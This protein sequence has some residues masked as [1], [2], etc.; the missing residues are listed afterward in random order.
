MASSKVNVGSHVC[1]SADAVELF[2]LP[3]SKAL[4]IMEVFDLKLCG[5][6][7]Q[8]RAAPV[9]PDGLDYTGATSWLFAS[10]FRVVG[11]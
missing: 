9:S 3:E 5:R 11:E 2:E 6:E 10:D 7:Y 4:V 8:F 1:F